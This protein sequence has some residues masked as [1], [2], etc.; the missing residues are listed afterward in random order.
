MTTATNYRIDR[1]EE[2]PKTDACYARAGM[3]L[4][5]QVDE[6]DKECR[7]FERENSSMRNLLFRFSCNMACAKDAHDCLSNREP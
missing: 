2:T 7:K 5:A 4:V 3:M 1:G 6:P